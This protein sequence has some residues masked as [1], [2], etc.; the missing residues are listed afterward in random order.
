M[1][2]KEFMQLLGKAYGFPD[3]YSLNLDSAEEI[4]EDIKEEEEKDRLSLKQFFDELLAQEPEEERA[5]IW[6][7]LADHF[8]VEEW[9]SWEEGAS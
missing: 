2:K 7:F 9:E 4:I 3:Y 8:V 1:D 6:A 5:K